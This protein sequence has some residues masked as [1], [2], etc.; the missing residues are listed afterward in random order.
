MPRLSRWLIRAALIYLLVG[1]VLGGLLLSAKAGVVDSRIWIWL[2]PHADILVAGW[3]IQLAMGMAFWIL[4]R[5]REAG[6]G[7]VLLA[8]A[9]FALLNVGLV[10][11]AG[12]AWL[13]YWFPGLTISAQAFPIGVLLQALALIVFAI[14]AW[15]RVLPVIIA[16]SH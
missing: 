12:L 9:S 13:Q 10:A 3:L 16:R 14:Y 5:I 15:P 1:F 11:G 8:W 4:P 6:R 2:L 7:R